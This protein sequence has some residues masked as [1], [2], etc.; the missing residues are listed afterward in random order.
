MGEPN[1]RINLTC[2]HNIQSYDTILWYQRSPGDPALK[3]IGFTRYTTIQ[4]IE[5]QHKD[6]FNVSGNGEK[7]AYL[8]ILK[9]RH[10]EDQG[11]YFCAAFNTMIKKSFIPQQKPLSDP[12]HLYQ[13]T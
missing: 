7:E 2:S 6:H 11:H 10:P 8:H 1:H 9:L 5:E 3:L 13:T 4:N 12:S